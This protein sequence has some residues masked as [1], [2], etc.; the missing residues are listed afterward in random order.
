[1]WAPRGAAGFERQLPFPLRNSWW[2]LVSVRLP[3]LQALAPGV[4]PAEGEPSLRRWWVEAVGRKH[5]WMGRGMAP[6]NEARR[7]KVL[8]C[9]SCSLLPRGLFPSSH[10]SCRRR[11][12]PEFQSCQA[13]STPLTH[14]LIYIIRELKQRGGP[15]LLI[16]GHLVTKVPSLGGFS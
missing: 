13:P 2:G 10:G 7:I 5:E 3:A 16:C 1:M 12:V 9:C 4:E 15:G 11:G 14:T 6:G 8:V